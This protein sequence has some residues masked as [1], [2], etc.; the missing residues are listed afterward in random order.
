MIIL[1]SLESAKERLAISVSAQIVSMVDV[2]DFEY[3]LALISSSSSFYLNQAT[4]PISIN[5][6]HIHI[7]TDRIK[8]EERKKCN[9]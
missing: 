2:F 3:N 1:D 7:Q 8:E 4:W 9:T 5:K 6:R